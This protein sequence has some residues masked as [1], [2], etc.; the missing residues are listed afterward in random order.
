MYN[1]RTCRADKRY[2][3]RNNAIMHSTMKYRFHNYIKDSPYTGSCYMCVCAS[4]C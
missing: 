2:I 3:S 1:I 4:R